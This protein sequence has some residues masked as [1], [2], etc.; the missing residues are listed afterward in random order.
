MKISKSQLEKIISEELQKEGILGAMRDALQAQKEKEK[1]NLKE[2]S[3][4]INCDLEE[5]KKILDTLKNYDLIDYI[6][7]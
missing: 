2:I 4:L 1:N 3:K 5:A 6:S 7:R